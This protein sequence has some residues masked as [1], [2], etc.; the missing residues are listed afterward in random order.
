MFSATAD[1][2][3]IGERHRVPGAIDYG[4][5]FVTPPTY[6]DQNWSDVADKLAANG[7]IVDRGGETDIPEDF[8]VTPYTGMKVQIPRG[9]KYLFLCVNDS[10]YADDT[11]SLTVTIEEVGA[12]E[13]G[14][15]HG[16]GGVEVTLLALS[17]G[18]RPP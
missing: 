10:F 12:V 14:Y 3:P 17:Q 9:A 6:M 7:I 8:L 16:L 4:K 5:D 13:D 2:K 11:G 15:D 18:G 1:L